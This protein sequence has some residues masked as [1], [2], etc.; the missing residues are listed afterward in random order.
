MGN[1]L[2]SKIL[3]FVYCISVYIFL[4][5]VVSAFTSPMFLNQVSESL[6]AVLIAYWIAKQLTRFRAIR[7][8]LTP[9]AFMAVQFVAM[10]SG[11]AFSHEISGTNFTMWCFGTAIILFIAA[12]TGLKKIVLRRNAAV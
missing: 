4:A 6:A 11:V 5:I 7:T 2:S 12:Q 10:V 1:I 8:Y 3:F 9:V